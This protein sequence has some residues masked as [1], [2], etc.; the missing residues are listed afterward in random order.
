[1]QAH[2]LAF[3]GKSKKKNCINSKKEAIIHFFTK[4]SNKTTTR[5]AN[6]YQKDNKSEEKVTKIYKLELQMHIN[7]Q[8][9]K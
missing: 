7:M 5:A 1:M 8:K 3:S 6:I 4:K 9:S 2:P